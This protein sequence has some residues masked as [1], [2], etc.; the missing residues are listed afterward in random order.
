[1][2]TKTSTPS[3][4]SPKLSHLRPQYIPNHIPDSSY[5]RI[6]DTTLRDG[7]QS[8]GATMT[9]K[10]KLDIARQ[11]VKLGVDIIQP[12]FPSASNSDFMAVKMIAQEVG[13]AVDDDGYVPVI[14]GF[15]RCVEKDISTAWEAVKYAKR[16]RLCTSIAT[17]P[18]HM[19]HKLR[20]SKDQVIQIARDMVKFA[21]SLGCNDIQFGAEDATRSDREFL[22]EILGVVIEAGATTVNIADTVGIVMP[23]ELGKL[24]VDIKDNTPGIANVIIS[25]HCHNDLGL[26]TANTIEGART[27]ARQL[28][29]TING[30]GERAGN[31][32]LEEVVMALASKGDHALNGLYT[33]INTRHILETSKMVEEYSGMH[34]QPHKP[35]VGANAFVHASGIHQDGMLK[36]KGTYETISPEE[37]GHKRTTRIGIVLGKLS[38]S[39][40]LRKRL[41]ELGY[42]LKEDEVDSVF[43]QFKAMAEKK[44]VTCG[45]IG[46]STATVK[47]VNIDGSTHVA[48]SI[49]IGAV[50]S[51]Y[52]AINLIVKEPTKLLD[53]SLN[54][55]TEGIG[56]NVTARVVICRE[57]NHTSTYAFTEDANYPT[58]SGI[59]AEMDVVVSTVKAYLVALNKL[60]RWK[61]SFRCA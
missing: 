29:V 40:A 1:M 22:Y 25:T 38:G 28:E 14:A 41:E 20:K 51:T 47:L 42:D 13:N 6:L 46:L 48:C 7:E 18:I 60:L 31:A 12:G 27:G 24:I 45:T 10:E 30:I 2:P 11:L 21:R 57:N 5:V 8:P 44:K 61:E 36:H 3:S 39:Q 34:L 15:C 4:Q 56:V 55:V 37:I 35:L 43:W 58:F 50:D 53:Y 17:S 49:G 9:A 52:K 19:E 59:A 23:L 26:A 54:S 32:S 33:R 16:P